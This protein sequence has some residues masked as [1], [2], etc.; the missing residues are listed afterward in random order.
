E[1]SQ[2]SQREKKSTKPFLPQDPHTTPPLPLSLVAHLLLLTSPSCPRSD[3][4]T[5]PSSRSTAPPPARRRRDHAVVPIQPS[6]QR[7]APSTT[8]IP[9]GASIPVAGDEHCGVSKQH[10]SVLSSLPFHVLFG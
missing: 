7:A 6:E 3:N 9:G 2:K 8:T 4:L 10:A 1:K 5:N